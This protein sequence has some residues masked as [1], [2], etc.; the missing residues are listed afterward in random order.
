MLWWYRQS[1]WEDA[2][3]LVV[4]IQRRRAQTHSKN[5]EH[6]LVRRKN[7]HEIYRPLH[8]DGQQCLTKDDVLWQP[9]WAIKPLDKTLKSRTHRRNAAV[10]NDVKTGW[11]HASSSARPSTWRK[12][13]DDDDEYTIIRRILPTSSL[14]HKMKKVASPSYPF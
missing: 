14:L 11:L 1:G 4:E 12:P 7:A 6:E 9:P 13:N 3:A 2:V 5:P 8:Q 10:Q